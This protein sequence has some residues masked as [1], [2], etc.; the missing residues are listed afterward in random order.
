MKSYSYSNNNNTGSSP[1]YEVLSRQ[2]KR[3]NNEDSFQVF[4]LTPRNDRPPIHILAVA[5]GMGGHAYGEEASVQTLR[6]LSLTLFESLTVNSSVNSLPQQTPEIT[7][8]RLAKT[9]QD[10]LKAANEHIRRMVKQNNW[11][12]SGSTVVVAA[13]IDDTAIVVNLGDSP[14]FHYQARNKRLTQVTE[15]HTIAGVLQRSGMITAEMAR[16]HEGKSRLQFFVGCSYFPTDLPTYTLKLEPD[17]LLLLCSDGVNGSLLPQD[18][19]NILASKQN[20]K[21]KAK[22]LVDKALDNKETDNQT[23]ILWSHLPSSN[24]DKSVSKFKTN[25]NNS[26]FIEGQYD[27]AEG[28]INLFKLLVLPLIFFGSLSFG[29]YYFDVL[30]FKNSQQQIDQQAA[31]NPDSEIEK[32]T[33]E[34][35]SENQENNQELSLKSQENQERYILNDYFSC[36]SDPQPPSESQPYKLQIKY[37]REDEYN[38]VE[39]LLLTVCPHP[40]NDPTKQRFK[41]LP[42]EFTFEVWFNKPSE[43]E[44]FESQIQQEMRKR[45]IILDIV[46]RENLNSQDNS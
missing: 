20:L 10:A 3:E 5:D 46:S 15:D 27:E 44:N 33:P 45:R 35:D 42:N 37:Y 16:N 9:L 2:N 22:A 39:N 38:Q 30:G 23:L 43:M 7:P 25:K 24:S 36:D 18:I 19:A 14:L 28:G 40:N 32:I 12:V 1:L 29:V 8:D 34:I 13:I 4:S 17:D 41:K 11:G 31:T 6:K 26:T 21:E